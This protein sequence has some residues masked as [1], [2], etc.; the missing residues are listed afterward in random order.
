MRHLLFIAVIGAIHCALGQ[1]KNVEEENL[2]MLY[3]DLRGKT[4]LNRKELREAVSFASPEKDPY[5]KLWYD[6]KIDTTRN[7]YVEY[8]KL[9]DGSDDR[10]QYNLLSLSDQE[11]QTAL[12]SVTAQQ[13]TLHLSHRKHCGVC[14]SLDD[15]F[16]YL[17][18]PD[19]TTPVRK[20]TLKL[21]DR[22]VLSCL[23]DLGF[24]E[25]CSRIWFWNARNTRKLAKNG[26]CFLSCIANLFS[27]NNVPEG[28]FNPCEPKH[29][30]KKK[31]V[32]NPN[33][34]LDPE[35]KPEVYG[36][37]NKNSG[38]CGN[39]LSGEKELSTEYSK[40]KKG[41]G[42]CGNTINGEPACHETQWKNG[43]YRLNP[44]LQ[45]DEC[46]SGPIFQRVSGRTRRNS[47]IQSA[48]DRPG[49]IPIDHN[50][51]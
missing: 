45:C 49:V 10:T 48:I 26:G 29:I 35:N 16:V 13:R 42:F 51:G 46:R 43:P 31:E 27:P 33:H 41:R 25:D 15:L 4:L 5:P 7:C 17:T 1:K 47:G 39:C 6:T 38:Q 21:L 44:C 3:G 23:R 28:K 20:C 22:N 30:D 2:R 8:S 50:Y 12:S 37:D 11:Y 24:S 9:P 14:S 18:Y 36:Q 34:Y 19:L 32:E 40:K